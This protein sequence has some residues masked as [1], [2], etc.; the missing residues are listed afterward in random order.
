MNGN[1]KIVLYA[2]AGV[3]ISLM[4]VVAMFVSGIQFPGFGS[5]AVHTGTLMVLLT[6]APVN[7][8]QLNVTINSFSILHDTGEISLIDRSISFDLLA[9]NNVTETISSSQVPVGKYT[10]MRMT[11]TE[12][13]ATFQDGHCDVLQVPPG[14]IDIIAHFEVE[15]DGVTVIL[16]DMQADW[17]AISQS[18]SLRPV[19]KVRSITT[20]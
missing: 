14:K 10:K 4:I 3:L 1:G 6:D 13:N 12:A 18:G 17:V 8:T 5:P 19:L 9:L 16:I 15:N 2:V 20:S 7:L 11:V